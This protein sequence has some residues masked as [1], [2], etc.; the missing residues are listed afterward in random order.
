MKLGRAAEQREGE[1]G[2]QQQ[3]QGSSDP[4]YIQSAP[5][6]NLSIGLAGMEAARPTARGDYDRM[7]PMVVGVAPRREGGESRQTRQCRSLQPGS[8]MLGGLITTVC[9]GIA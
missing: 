6:N 7:I 5:A 9:I 8:G 1:R 4:N 3:L 2:T